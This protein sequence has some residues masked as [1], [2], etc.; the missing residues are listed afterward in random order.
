MLNRRTFDAETVKSTPHDD[1]VKDFDI[2]S[3]DLYNEGNSPDGFK[4]AVWI[5]FDPIFHTFVHVGIYICV[6]GVIIDYIFARNVDKRINDI[7][8]ILKCRFTSKKT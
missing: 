7:P 8:D 6:L 3:A 4:S 2:E 5:Q 1:S